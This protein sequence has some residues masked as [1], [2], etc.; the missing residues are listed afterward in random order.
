MYLNLQ[1]FKFADKYRGRYD[2]NLDVKHGYYPSFSGY[3]DELLW[4]ALWLYRATEN[5]NYLNYAI[6]NAAIYGGTTWSS[7]E[8]TWDVKHPG[9]QILAST[10]CER[11]YFLPS[12]IYILNIFFNYC[13]IFNAYSI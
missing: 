5:Y 7:K 4:A 6:E 12:F 10:V 3:L 1:L 13:N 8:F 9:L 11:T 2:Y